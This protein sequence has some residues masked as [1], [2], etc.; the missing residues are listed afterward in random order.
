LADLAD[1]SEVRRVAQTLQD[2]YPA[3]DILINNAGVYLADRE[4]TP[5]GFEK[6]FAVN[7]LAPFLLTR[8]L[9]PSL[10]KASSARV[11]NLTSVGHQLGLWNWDNLQGEKWYM[12]HNAYGIGKAANIMFT[13]ELARRAVDSEVTVTCVHP[14]MIRS[15]FAKDGGGIL[16]V[17]ATIFQ[18]F[19]RSST[20]GAAP[21]IRLAVDT[22]SGI[23]SGEYYSRM[24][25]SR[26]SRV[27]RDPEACRRL[28][29][30][31]E[32]LLGTT[33]QPQLP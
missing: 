8:L 26:S 18:W 33:A 12:A 25:R 4:L 14:G 2:R 21:V 23:E 11:V 29:E 30:L 17:G 1:M 24:R 22:G 10:T 6:T 16:G 19:L 20:Q 3:I 27:T 5:D 13:R 9:W 7:H 32:S 31:S 15:N 28:W